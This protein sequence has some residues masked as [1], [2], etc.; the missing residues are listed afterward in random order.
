MAPFAHLTYLSIYRLLTFD[1]LPLTF[2]L[3]PSTLSVRDL[4]LCVSSEEERDC[5][6]HFVCELINSEI[7]SGETVALQCWTEEE[8]E[9]MPPLSR[10]QCET[11]SIYRS[12][13]RAR[14][15]SSVENW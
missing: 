15:P 5:P 3:S 9:E 10:G 4:S 8:D 7:L 13:G 11:L 12:V 6:V 14:W 1:R 2:S